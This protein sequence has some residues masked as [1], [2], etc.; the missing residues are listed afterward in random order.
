MN[1][2]MHQNSSSGSYLNSSLINDCSH[3]FNNNTKK[4][5]KKMTA[6]HCSF[7]VNL[8]TEEKISCW[9]IDDKE[10]KR[11]IKLRKEADEYNC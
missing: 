5:E 3:K 4:F 10:R 8:T 11:Q 1:Q 9:I 6:K 2:K 7:Y